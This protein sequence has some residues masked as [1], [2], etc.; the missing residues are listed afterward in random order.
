MSLLP[1]K[2]AMSIF[3]QTLSGINY[4][5]GKGVIHRDLKP[6]NV[7]IDRSGDVKLADFGTARIL[8]MD[9]SITRTGQLI[10]TPDYMS[11]EQIRGEKARSGL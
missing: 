7:M 5:H 3:S 6:A 4:A 8:G 2:E 10:G 1:F 9:T 11:P